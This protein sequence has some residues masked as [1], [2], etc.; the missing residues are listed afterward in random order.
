MSNSLPALLEK[1]T[2]EFAKA[3]GS[4]VPSE[5]FVRIAQ[6]AINSNPTIANLDRTSLLAAIMQAAQD[7]LVL[8]NKEAA[9]VPFKGKATYIPM[10][11]GV[12]KKMRQHSGFENISFGIIYK[13][14]VDTGAFEYVKGDDEYLKHEP[15]MFDDRGEAVGAY[16]VVSVNGEK[17]RSVLR[18]DQII[19]RLSK[20]A[21]SGAKKEWEDEFWIKTVI[22]H[23][24][25]KAPNSGDEAGVLD[26]VFETEDG[27]LHDSDGVVQE[28]SVV[29]DVEPNKPKTSR[30]AAKVKAMSEDVADAE[31]VPDDDLPL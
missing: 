13:N 29:T 20:G 12:I 9:I 23:V 15:I 10:V 4:S 5:R 18:K 14:E 2:P 24:A 27:T 21:N 25:K 1:M 30:A 26:Q 6:S 19:K 22:K 28:E 31:V 16:A 11:A 8:D 7:G 3:L 17:F